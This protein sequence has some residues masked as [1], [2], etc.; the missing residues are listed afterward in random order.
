MDLTQL[1]PAGDEYANVTH[2]N[3]SGFDDDDARGSVLTVKRPVYLA[4]T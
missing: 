2:L 3:V 4:I 1:L